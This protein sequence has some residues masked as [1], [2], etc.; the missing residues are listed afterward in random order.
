MAI[1]TTYVFTNTANYTYNESTLIVSGGLVG[2]N[3][4]DGSTLI[5][6]ELFSST[7][8]F[9]Y[10]T[11][12][13]SISAGKLTQRDQRPANATFYTECN[14]STIANWGE[15]T[16]TA[17]TYNSAAISNEWL[18]LTGASGKY[19]AYPGTGNAS[20]PMEGTV[21]F[22]VRPNY[23]GTPTE[24]QIFFIVSAASGDSA[25]AMSLA[26][27][28][29][30]GK[31]YYTVLNYLG[32]DII[33]EPFLDWAPNSG[34]SY[35]IE[36]GY[37]LINGDHRFFIDGT[38]VGSIFTD[39]GTRDDITLFRWGEKLVLFGDA[40]FSLKNMLIFS[41]VQH[42]A[43]YTA[44][45]S[46]SPTVYHGDVITAPP[47]VYNG[48][49]D[50]QKYTTLTATYSNDIYY[51]FNDKYWSGAE[52]IT[53]NNT[54]TQANTL[55]EAVENITTLTP[56]NTTIFK[57]LTTET[58]TYQAQVDIFNIFYTPQ[59]YN[60]VGASI[61]PT[62]KIS[63]DAI[64]SVTTITSE[65]ANDVIQYNVEVNN[66]AKYW[67]GSEWTNAVSDYLTTNDLTTVNS[68]LSSLDISIGS[69]IRIS[70][71]LKSD[72]GSFTPTLDEL[73]IST[74]FFGS[75]LDTADPVVVYGYL[76]DSQNDP[77]PNVLINAGLYQ[78][79]VYGKQI[80]FNTEATSTFTNS[81]GYWEMNLID[82]EGMLPQTQYMFTFTGGY[83]SVHELKTIPNTI[84][85]N[86][87]DL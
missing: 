66:V 45:E 61:T 81:I 34:T 15:G 35:E 67:N 7:D 21:R 58:N 16:L 70:S 64:N 25:N 55:G 3:F 5:F 76:Y 46:I 40:D 75:S 6:Q 44:G 53:S 54:Y 41:T 43:D 20:N 33:R 31:L 85:I 82:N 65:T 49:G 39:T 86:Y 18:D 13:T 48:V 14:T 10:N 84:S 62:S 79:A 60:T 51:I 56:S 32:T 9:T 29:S 80:L 30:D 1:T 11:S 69:Q 63:A 19:I 71:W 23:T 83:V 77:L 2:L 52:W 36:F 24:D 42:T 47:K 73:S 17:S 87:G 37:D 12:Y 26:H 78:N 59:I 74:N 4:Q 22:T 72:A 8:S 28:S 27:E 57:I 50:V 38:R 68:N